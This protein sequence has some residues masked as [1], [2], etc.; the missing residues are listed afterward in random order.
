MSRRRWRAVALAG[1]LALLACGPLAAE[2]PERVERFVYGGNVW[3]G[4]DVVS[5]FYP[6]TVDTLYVLAG[7][8]SILTGRR[9]LVYYWP[10]ESRYLADW[11]SLNEVVAGTLE[12]SGPGGT[13]QLETTV[14]VV[15]YEEGPDGLPSLHLGEQA[16]ARYEAFRR[17]RA[18][19]NE[20]ASAYQQA[21]A[22]Y[23]AALDDARQ[24]RAGGESV[25]LPESPQSPDDFVWLSTPPNPGFAIDLPAGSYRLRMLDSSGETVLGSERKLEVIVP[26]RM[27]VSYMLVPES[28]WTAPEHSGDA[29]QTLYIRPGATLYLQP[30]VAMQVDDAAFARL[31]DPQSRAGRAGDWRWVDVRPLTGLTLEVEAGGAKQYVSQGQFDVRQIPGAALGYEVVPHT[32]RVG[33]APD[34]VGYRLNI[35]GGAVQL[36][37]ENGQPAA[38]S[39]RV[40]RPLR[41]LS[42]VSLLSLSLLPLAVGGWSRARERR[43]A[44]IK[45]T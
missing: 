22:A 19:F 4:R 17:A 43:R 16:S 14:Y 2:Q 29:G 40:A 44:S 28:R 32:G 10:L 21:Q 1:A 42:D 41:P 12:V 25:A 37:D 13:R 38:G 24:R 26:R 39:R 23:R 5:T 3:N 30:F 36:L 18:A 31:G 35:E 33:A 34:I 27:G 8:P 20:A 15:Q 7:Q 45:S 6:P 9:T 11:D